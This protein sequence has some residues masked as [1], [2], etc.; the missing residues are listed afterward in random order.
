MK[1]CAS[2]CAVT[3]TSTSTPGAAERERVTDRRR[4]RPD[5]LSWDYALNLLLRVLR[6]E[7]RFIRVCRFGYNGRYFGGSDLGCI[8][9]DFRKEILIFQHFSNLQ[10]LRT[11]VCIQS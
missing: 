2:G 6:V 7:L 1:N 11:F 8:A 5:G 10:D 9:A 4:R 3:H